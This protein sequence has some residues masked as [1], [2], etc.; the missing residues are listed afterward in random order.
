VNGRIQRYTK[1]GLPVLFWNM[2]PRAYVRDE[3]LEEKFE[4]LV[5]ACKGY[6][7][8][9][10]YGLVVESRDETVRP[11]F[12][13]ALF[14]YLMALNERQGHWR[15]F[16]YIVDLLRSTKFH[17]QLWETFLDDV[18]KPARQIVAIEGMSAKRM[19]L[20]EADELLRLTDMFQRFF[21]NGCLV[22]VS[23]PDNQ[24]RFEKMLGEDLAQLMS[25]N[26]GTWGKLE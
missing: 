7:H 18:T 17:Q 1:S 10:T 11:A 25:D 26:L 2:K 16:S 8:N 21:Q 12:T 14:K 19:A 4:G 20:L 6:S 13:A 5:E 15:T 22:I 23:T 9:E 24:D 3:G